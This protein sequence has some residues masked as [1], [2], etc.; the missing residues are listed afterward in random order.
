MRVGNYSITFADF[1]M[2]DQACAWCKERG[3]LLSLNSAS[4][5]DPLCP[6]LF[7]ESLKWRDKA[8]LTSRP[9]W[10]KKPEAM[11]NTPYTRTLWLDLDCEV[12]SPLEPL[13]DTD[14]EGSAIALVPEAERHQKSP[15]LLPNEVLYNSGVILYESPSALITL[16]AEQAKSAT[17][18][19][20]GD[21]E[22]L[23][24]LIVEHGFRIKELSSIYNWHMIEG[25]LLDVRI[26]H[27]LGSLGKA[28][29]RK[30]GGLI[31]FL[32]KRQF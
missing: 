31:S 3:E 30:E 23:S 8:H 5:V 25:I 11:Q 14:L 15:P 18:Q 32:S 4:S 13:F 19:F 6:K 12:L 17:S 2:T 24:R 10:F 27:W 26:V 9:G 21:Q 29:I 22:L 16:W 7:K 20:R 1:G 28:F